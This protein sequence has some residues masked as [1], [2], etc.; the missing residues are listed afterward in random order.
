[1][2]YEQWLEINVPD[3]RTYRCNGFNDPH[4]G[5]Y[6][7]YQKYIDSQKDLSPPD[8]LIE[9]TVKFVQEVADGIGDCSIKE[10][11]DYYEGNLKCLH[12][13]IQKQMLKQKK[14]YEGKV[15]VV[16]HKNALLAAI[17]EC[18]DT[19]VVLKV[20][21]GHSG[22]GLYVSSGVNIWNGSYFL[23]IE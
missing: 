14:L 3:W 5:W 13:Y 9:D 18:K 11:D 16:V 20:H 1:M 2:T 15:G 23:E 22:H 10:F 6:Y 17:E 7:K 21:D 4:E 19:L 8:A 12:S